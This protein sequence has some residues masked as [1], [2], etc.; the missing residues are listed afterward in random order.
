MVL[1]KL[2]Y[3]KKQ[4]VYFSNPTNIRHF[5]RWLTLVFNSI[6]QGRVEKLGPDRV[7]AEWLLRN[8]ASVRWKGSD[9]F[10]RDYNLLPKEDVKQYI[11]AVDATSSSIHHCGFKHFNGCKYIEEIKL[12]D[13]LSIENDAMLSLAILKNSLKL[14][15]VVN[16][17]NITDEGLHHLSNLKNLTNLKLGG[18]PYV[19]N[20][21]DVLNQ[22]ILS[23]PQCKIIY[24]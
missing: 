11:S 7:C 3:A 2:F 15:E 9:D 19:K 24:T 22:L 8:G 16:C 21:N 12:I 14:L 1:N 17:K 4:N 10:L 23:L 6:D 20:K 18:F 13:C 5:F